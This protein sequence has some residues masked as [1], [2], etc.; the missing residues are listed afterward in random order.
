MGFRFVALERSPSP[1][2]PGA[3]RASV[4]STG[5]VNAR[6]GESICST[7]AVNART[8][9]SDCSTGVANTSVRDLGR[10][11]NGLRKSGPRR[12]EPDKEENSLGVRRI[13]Y[14]PVGNKPP[15]RSYRRIIALIPKSCF[16]ISS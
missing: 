4:C 10:Q 13:H 1:N 2:L 3:L 5:A 12:R 7:E 15:W 9:K 6:L 16:A 14:L 11:G 8:D